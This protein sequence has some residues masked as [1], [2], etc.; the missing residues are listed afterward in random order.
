MFDRLFNY[1]VANPS[2]A[3]ES[4]LDEVF[5]II[6]ESLEFGDAENLKGQMAKLDELQDR[7]KKMREEE[8][9]QK[10]EER[11]EDVLSAF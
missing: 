9:R 11:P 7:M 2:G 10:S 5:D 4:E 3:T 8:E 6:V 1:V